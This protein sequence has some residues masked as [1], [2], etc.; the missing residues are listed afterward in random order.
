MET[1]DIT[2]DDDKTL[3][4]DYVPDENE[5]GVKRPESYLF[6]EAFKA[7]MRYDLSDD[8]T[9]TIINAVLLALN[10]D[11]MIIEESSV[12]RYLTR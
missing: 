9:K 10:K 2:Y 3:D 1:D 8:A 5:I 12:K 6:A 11:H 4:S 7:C